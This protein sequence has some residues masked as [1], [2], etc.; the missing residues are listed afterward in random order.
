MS[1]PS[2]SAQRL[3]FFAEAAQNLGSLRQ[4]DAG[5]EDEIDPEAAVHHFGIGLIE[6][7]V[8]ELFALALDD[9]HRQGL[10]IG[11]EERARAVL[12]GAG[13][14]EIGC[15]DGG[16]VGGL[17]RILQRA[18]NVGALALEDRLQRDRS[19]VVVALQLV[20]ADAVEEAYISYSPWGSGS[21]PN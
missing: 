6:A 5:L 7:Q 17:A 1:Q 19:A 16:V 2:I 11:A 4:T 9:G 15:A 13:V 3:R 14:A 18:Q 12:D 8:A 20:A 21:L 10:E